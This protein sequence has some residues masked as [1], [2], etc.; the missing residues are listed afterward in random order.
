MQNMS[1]T[2]PDQMIPA[3]LHAALDAILAA[4][5]QSVFQ[6]SDG[7]I[8]FVNMASS[9][10]TSNKEYKTGREI[11]DKVSNFFATL[12]IK[13]FATLKKYPDKILPGDTVPDSKWDPAVTHY[14]QNLLAQAGG[15]TNARVTTE[16]YSITQV[17]TEFSTSFIKILFDAT[18]VPQNIIEDV[19]KFIQGVGD[20]L[21]VGWDDKSKNF[22]TALLSQCHEAVPVDASGTAVYFPKI[23][24]IY[25]SV[26]SE[27]TVFTSPCINVKKLTFNFKYEY[28][29][30]AL[31]SSILDE[32]SDDHKR[33]VGFLNKAQEISYKDADNNLDAI[34]NDTLSDQTK[35][36]EF[37][38]DGTNVFS[39]SLSEYPSVA[40]DRKGMVERSVK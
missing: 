18:A 1:F 16:S 34:L 33:F 21:R 14:M 9:F 19:T 30:T 15:L 17:I 3:E 27:Q 35:K 26:N 13:V 25:I 38:A 31:K 11:C 22:S 6:D 5:D 24:Y 12:R 4:D 8:S 40:I 10:V 39:V 2:N 28:Y 20:T 32:N 7:L 29:V 37:V 36:L 23:K